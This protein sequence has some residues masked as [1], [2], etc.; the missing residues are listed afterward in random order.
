MESSRVLISANGS[1]VT[2][3]ARL[4][5]FWSVLRVVGPITMKA[6]TLAC[7]PGELDLV[8]PTEK[9][10]PMNHNNMVKRHFRPALK[11]ADIEQ[12]R[13]HDMR[14]TYASLL[15]EQGENIKYIQT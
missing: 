5:A 12:I 9:G 7:P 10:T 8:F 3:P 2:L 4:Q 6:L 11:T 15:I 14:H 1:D 13:F